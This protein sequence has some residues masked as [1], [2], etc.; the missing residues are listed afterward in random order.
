L[1]FSWNRRLE[2]RFEGSALG[3]R[4]LDHDVGVDGDALDGSVS[5][6]EREG[7]H[8]KE[9]REVFVPFQVDAGLPGSAL[10]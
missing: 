5:G 2:Q 9:H 8:A 6:V 4:H 3:T 1:P 10:V 7:V